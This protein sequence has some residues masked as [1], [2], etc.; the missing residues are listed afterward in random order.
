MKNYFRGSSMKKLPGIAY[1]LRHCAARRRV[2]GS[3]PG[4]VAGDFFVA[5]EGT[6]YPGNDS[7]SK[8][9]YQDIPGGKDLHS[10]SLNLP[11]PLGPPRPV[12]GY[13]YLLP[14]KKFQK[15]CIRAL[16]NRSN[17]P[18]APGCSWLLST[19]S[20]LLAIYHFPNF[21]RKYL[22]EEA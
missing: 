17:T 5:T 8:N 18:N 21:D 20:H 11:E 6:M 7:V 14:R 1:W 10:R 3:I 19:T 4:G 15:H 2:S 12:A 9:E 22:K 13:L 16:S